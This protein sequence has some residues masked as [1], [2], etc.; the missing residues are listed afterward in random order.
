MLALKRSST[1]TIK[2]VG[3]FDLGRLARLHQACFEDPWSRPIS[4]T[5]S[6]CPAVLA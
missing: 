1:L 5:C 3:P 4:P 6:P 2:T